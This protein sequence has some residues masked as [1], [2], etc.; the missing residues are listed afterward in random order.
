MASV[1]LGN[2]VVVVLHVG[3]TKASG[4]KLRLKREPRS[5]KSWFPACNVLP[6]EEPIDTALRKKFKETGLTLT[7]DYLTM[8]SGALVRV[9]LPD[10]KLQHVYV[11]SASVRVPYVNANLRTQAKIE[12]ASQS[13]L[14]HDGSCFVPT[15]IGID[16]LT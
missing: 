15:T 7:V 1:G 11:Y 4:I 5:C 12:H 16:G 13:T 9:P 3:G 6:N 2:N 8:L 14:H 10:G